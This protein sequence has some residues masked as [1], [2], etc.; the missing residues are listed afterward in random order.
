VTWVAQP[1]NRAKSKNGNVFFN[2]PVS[3]AKT[4]EGGK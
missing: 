1:V 4:T 2:M 3:V